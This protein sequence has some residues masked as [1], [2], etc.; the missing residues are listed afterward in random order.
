MVNDRRII[1]IFNYFPSRIWYLINKSF[2]LLNKVRFEIKIITQ[3]YNNLREHLYL[4]FN[5]NI[6][7]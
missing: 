1:R 7:I 3:N 2:K 5:Q 6:F 4:I